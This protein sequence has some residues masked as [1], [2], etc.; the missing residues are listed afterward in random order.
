MRGH[1]PTYRMSGMRKAF[2][3]VLTDI[4]CKECGASS[5]ECLKHKHRCH[6]MFIR[7]VNALLKV[8]REHRKRT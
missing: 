6:S 7:E 4:V 1:S 8:V 5:E 3:K 2:M